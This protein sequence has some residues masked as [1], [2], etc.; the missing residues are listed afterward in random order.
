MPNIKIL[1]EF[2][3]SRS[4]IAFLLLNQPNVLKCP[5]NKFRITVEK[6]KQMGLNPQPVTFVIAV[7]ALLSMSKSTWDKKVEFLKKWGWSEDDVYVAFTK[8]PWC[9]TVSVNKMSST[10]DMLINKSGFD[11]SVVVDW[12]KCLAHSFEN[13]VVPRCLFY[14][15]LLE[16][17]LITERWKLSVLVGHSEAQF[18]NAVT[19]FYKEDAPELLKLY[20]EKSG[21]RD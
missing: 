8:Y 18:M 21:L 6:V 5:N 12:P 2:G 7:H 15:V 1:R 13:R 3:V 11:H 10:L 20:K 17:G 14:Q 9:M 19:K 4:S 16:R